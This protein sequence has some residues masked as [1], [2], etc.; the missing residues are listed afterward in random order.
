[1]IVK[2]MNKRRMGVSII[3]LVIIITMLIS[4][5]YPSLQEPIPTKPVMTLTGFPIELRTPKPTFLPT[6]PESQQ[7]T[8][9]IVPSLLATMEPTLTPFEEKNAILKLIENNASCKY[10]C[11]WGITPQKTTYSEIMKFMD[12]LVDIKSDSFSLEKSQYEKYG[13]ISAW[14]TEDGFTFLTLFSYNLDND[15]IEQLGYSVFV[16]CHS[17]IS[18]VVLENR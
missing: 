9:T 18:K 13:G 4:C 2:M 5:S 3:V 16:T 15:S 12:A 6:F 14:F 8:F 7:P 1:M 11:L 17:P 10:P